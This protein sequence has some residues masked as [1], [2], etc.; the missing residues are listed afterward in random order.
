MVSDLEAVAERY[1]TQHGRADDS[2]AQIRGLCEQYRERCETTLLD[3]LTATAAVDT[4]FG[5]DR[6]DVEAITPQMEEAFKLA[7]PR[8]N[9]VAKLESLSGLAADDDTVT[10]TVSNWKGKYFEV[11]VR[12][13]LNDGQQVGPLVLEEGQRAT[14]AG[15]QNQPDWDL[16]II[17]ADGSVD[18][19][20]QLKAATIRHARRAL[21]RYPDIDVIATNEAADADL[22]DRIFPS[23]FSNEDLEDDISDPMADVLDGPAEHLFEVLTPALPFA[24]ILVSEGRRVLVKRSTLAAAARRALERSSVTVTA[25]GVGGLAA[26]VGAGVLSMPAASVTRI[27]LA[28]HAVMSAAARKLAADHALV[29]SLLR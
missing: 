20:V 25:M 4:L 9:M 5:P 19:Q 2:D 6:V 3:T 18:E 17:D 24:I 10:G 8:L 21:G 11:L 26:L 27:A 15:A 22:G 1:R 14:L 13:R 28:R 12:D 16:Q 23:G 29:A 7:S